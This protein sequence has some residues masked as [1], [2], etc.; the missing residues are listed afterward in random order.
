MR[1]AADYLS[2]HALNVKSVFVRAVA[3]YAL[4]LH[5]SS[6]ISATLLLDSLEKLAREKGVCKTDAFKPNRSTKRIN[7]F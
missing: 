6:D 2:Q 3:T 4:T 7:G 5:D 1:S